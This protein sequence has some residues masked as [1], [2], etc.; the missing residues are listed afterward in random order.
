MRENE[1]FMWG[2]ADRQIDE[3]VSRGAFEVI[4]DFA[5]PLALLVI[6]DLL[7]V[8]EGD[9]RSFR[10]Q[11]GTEQP[12]AAAVAGDEA[13]MARDPL[14]FLFETFTAYIEE[15]RREPRNDV[16]TQLATATYPD[17]TTPEVAAVV[18]T[19]TFLFAAGQHTTAVLIAS[20]LRF[21]AERPDLQTLL[22]NEPE[23]IPACLHEVLRMEGPVK[24]IGRMAR[25]STSVGGVD[26]P[27]GATVALLPGAANRDPRHFEEPDE[28]RL[29]RPKAA[30]HLAFGWGIHTCPGAALAQTEA[31]IA[32]E[33]LLARVADIQISDAEHGPAGARR[34]EY[35][36]TYILRGLKALH[37]E[38]TPAETVA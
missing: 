37:L 23:R 38:F 13:A 5:Q 31:R 10:Y 32:I 9:H 14:R 1:E 8:P 29:D 19:A 12:A 34:F 22:R 3:F 28:F 17:G 20:A 24:T 15:R 7:G 18:R 16:L 30:A 11:L 21:L 25:V 4:H 26:V 27:A 2:L 33:R 6:A 35:E 36:A